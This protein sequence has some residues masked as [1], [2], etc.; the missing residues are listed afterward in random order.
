[1]KIKILKSILA[2]LLIALVCG[3]LVCCYFLY[4]DIQTHVPKTLQ[5]TSNL[6]VSQFMERRV[7]VLSP[8]DVNKSNMTIL[9]LHGGS[10]VAEATEKHWQFLE[11]IVTDTGATVIL[12]DY[13]LTPKYTYHDVF[14]MIVPFY[15]ELL[16]KIS[17]DSLVLMG[18]SAGGGM[19]LALLEE[20]KKQEIP[21]PSQTILIS[22]WLDVTLENPQIDEVQKLDKQL[23]KE[24]L[25]LAGITY[26]GEDGMNSY[27]VNPILGDL[28]GLENI[29]V[30]I[31]TYD[32]LN[33]DVHLL[34]EKAEKV[35]TIINVYEY[36]EASHIWVIENN[37]SQEL[38]E[39]GYH[40]I[41]AKLQGKTF[42]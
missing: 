9:Y 24:A 42:D 11:N 34:K 30:F 6:Q 22:P 33:P 26:A 16:Q 23:S 15:K 5:P 2:T 21:M 7:F 40:D 12:P 1:M 8:S 28:T 18:D 13:P 3:L 17:S 39:K 10:Y 38:V 19:G 36:K 35:G 20:I 37:S 32:I 27:L 25:K 41:I 14:D 29:C 31:G 4:N